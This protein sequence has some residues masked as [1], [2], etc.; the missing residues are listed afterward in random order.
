MGKIPTFKF[1]A[2]AWLTITAE[3]TDSGSLPGMDENV[4]GLL[5]ENVQEGAIKP[6]LHPQALGIFE[7]LADNNKT[8]SDDSPVETRSR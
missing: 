5:L 3:S 6:R 7:S 1:M 4:K 2:C 8:S